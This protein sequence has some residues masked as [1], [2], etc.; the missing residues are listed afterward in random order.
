MK[1][2]RFQVAL[3]VAAA[4]HGGAW[5]AR[6]A[7]REPPPPPVTAMS[8]VEEA[9][10]DIDVSQGPSATGEDQGP[11]GSVLSRHGWSSATR[12][13]ARDDTTAPSGGTG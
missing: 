11:Q 3:A 8:Y 2:S 10:V 12:S 6:A 7:V 9:S 5:L 4:L 1:P 13:T